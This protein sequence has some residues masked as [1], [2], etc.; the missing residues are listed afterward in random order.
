MSATPDA[1]VTYPSYLRL[2]ELLSLQAPRSTPEHP[3][4]LLF[5]VVH[6]ASE[7]WF[8]VIL[9]ELDGLVAAMAGRDVGGALWR[10]TPERVK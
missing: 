8:K 5:I 2:D 7:L 10:A 6:Q 3:D 9:H 1:D 4:E